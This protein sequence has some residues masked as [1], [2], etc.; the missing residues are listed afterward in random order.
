MLYSLPKV[1]KNQT[2]NHRK[3]KQ[4]CK[5]FTKSCNRVDIAFT[6]KITIFTKDV[7]ET[8]F[9]CNPSMELKNL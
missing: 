4:N 3:R 8:L 1:I 9:Q 6:I 2:R 7:S 5:R